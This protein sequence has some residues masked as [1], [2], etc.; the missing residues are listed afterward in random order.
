MMMHVHKSLNLSTTILSDTYLQQK[1][2][3]VEIQESAEPHT[4]QLEQDMYA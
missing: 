3:Q 4:K 2:P 1:Q